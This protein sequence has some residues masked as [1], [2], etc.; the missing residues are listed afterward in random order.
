MFN[1][2]IIYSITKKERIQFKIN[3]SL[4]TLRNLIIMQANTMLQEGLIIYLL[5]YVR[6]GWLEVKF[7]KI[8]MK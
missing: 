7:D 5:N 1:S 3:N 2:F 4:I 8:N 6:N